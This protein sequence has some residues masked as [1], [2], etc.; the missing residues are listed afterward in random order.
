MRTPHG[1]AEVVIELFH[2]GLVSSEPQVIYRPIH[3]V[4]HKL[5]ILPGLEF[6]SWP[7]C[8][9]WTLSRLLPA[10]DYDECIFFISSGNTHERETVVNHC[11]AA[12][13]FLP[14]L[15]IAD[16]TIAYN[17]ITGRQ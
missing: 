10:V 14:L 17:V 16:G 5:F 7:M 4:C 12:R 9:I 6:Y 13:T 3:S 2:A 1:R 8:F 11:A 15:H